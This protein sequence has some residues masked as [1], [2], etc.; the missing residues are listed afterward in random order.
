MRFIII[1]KKEILSWIIIQPVYITKI[2][3]S[4]NIVSIAAIKIKLSIAVIHVNRAI[5]L[6]ENFFSKTKVYITV[7]TNIHIF[8]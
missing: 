8:V 2:I 5:E 4:S 6:C 7:K 1:S 3:V